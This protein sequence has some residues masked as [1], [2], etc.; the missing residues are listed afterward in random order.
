MRVTSGEVL[1]F[2]ISTPYHAVLVGEGLVRVV[3]KG[4]KERIVPF[5]RKALEAL[6]AYIP[7]RGRLLAK[8]RRQSRA[9]RTANE[10]RDLYA[11]GRHD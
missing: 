9:D 5:G 11:P 6:E 1:A 10:R 8:N 4:R 3:G 2:V 7:A